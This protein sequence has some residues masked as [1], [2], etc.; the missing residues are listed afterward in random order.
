L[1]SSI[2]AIKLNPRAAEVLDTLSQDQPQE[3]KNN[4]GIEKG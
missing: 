3:Y 4:I 1:I 2:T